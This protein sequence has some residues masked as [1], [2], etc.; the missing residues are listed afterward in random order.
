MET[1]SDEDTVNC[2][3]FV[4]FFPGSYIWFCGAHASRV[5]QWVCFLVQQ[6]PFLLTQW[7]ATSLSGFGVGLFIILALSTP[8]T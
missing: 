3:D 7:S 2:A 6:V 1:V 8:N 5:G 4:S